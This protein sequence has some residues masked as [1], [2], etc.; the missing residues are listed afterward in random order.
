MGAGRQADRQATLIERGWGGIWGA[1]SRDSG[2]DLR[3]ETERGLM[4][5]SSEPPMQ[6]TDE[7]MKEVKRKERKIGANESEREAT[8]GVT[9]GGKIAKHGE[10]G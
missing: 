5:V 9:M 3:M 6:N 1:S 8:K 4:S 2:S 7:R 10:E